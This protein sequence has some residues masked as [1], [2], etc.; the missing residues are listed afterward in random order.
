MKRAIITLVMAMALVGNIRAIGIEL[1][2]V[3]VM[4]NS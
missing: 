1:D 4:A 3:E 2:R